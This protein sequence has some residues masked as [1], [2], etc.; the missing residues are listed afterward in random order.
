MKG[1]IDHEE[2]LIDLQIIGACFGS[3]LEPHLKSDILKLSSTVAKMCN[4]AMSN[5]KLF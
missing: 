5:D 3:N 1:W 2:L 4:A